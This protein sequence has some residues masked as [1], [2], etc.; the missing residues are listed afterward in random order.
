MERTVVLIKPDGMQKYIVG[1]IISRFE[2]AGLKLVGLKMIMLTEDI[3]KVWYAHHA[4]KPFFPQLVQDMMATPVVAMVLEGE[5][6]IQKVFD[7]CGPT[8]P[9][10][11]APGTIR[12]DFGE[13]KPKNVV[14]RSDSAEAAAKE[15]GLLFRS[16][17]I[18]I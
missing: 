10:E 17:E 14:H 8:D 16:E 18:L 11:A 12:K 6:A 2:K 3:L 4:D 15:V 7:I 1:E 9:A 5:G 13:S